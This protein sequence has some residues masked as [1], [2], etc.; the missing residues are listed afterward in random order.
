MV[1]LAWLAFLTLGLLLVVWRAA[2]DNPA[3]QGRPLLPA[4][5][6]VTLLVM[7]G[8]F[9]LYLAGQ[10]VCLVSLE[11]NTPERRAVK[12]SLGYWICG[13][14]LNV[15][16]HFMPVASLLDGILVAVSFSHFL[17]FL[18]HLCVN[19]SNV[20]LFTSINWL[21]RTYSRALMVG[22]GIFMVCLLV[23]VGN[24]NITRTILLTTALCLLLLLL[25]VVV[26]LIGI[27]GQIIAESGELSDRQPGI[28]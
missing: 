3:P 14:G 1:R 8:G 17:D 12:L 5:L 20:R 18:K 25:F 22:V 15:A 6:I 21:S 11:T 13:I 2:M 28:A 19:F 9:V 4:F 24:A 16:G 27:L 10:I 23:N 7:T 26:R